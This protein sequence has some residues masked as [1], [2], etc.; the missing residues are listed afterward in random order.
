MDKVLR[1]NRHRRIRSRIS[2]TGDRPRACLT[3]SLTRIVVQLID[4]TSHRTLASATGKPE[5]VGKAIGAAAS[6]LGIKKIVFDRGGYKYHGR[7]KATA[8]AMR[9]AGLEF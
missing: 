1:K 8:E 7:V 4:D 9:K 2:G 6:E 5:E 3:R